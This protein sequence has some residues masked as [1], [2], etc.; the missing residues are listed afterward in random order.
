[1]LYDYA[2]SIKRDVDI[3]KQGIFTIEDP[4]QGNIQL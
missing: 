4:Y 1:M 2:D 3:I